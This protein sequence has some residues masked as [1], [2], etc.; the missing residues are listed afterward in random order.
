[1]LRRTQA[2]ILGLATAASAAILPMAAGQDSTAQAA[3]RKQVTTDYTLLR[4]SPAS[5]VL[6]TAYRNWTVDVH[7]DQNNGYRWG[8]V[9]GDLN[10]CLW[11]YSGALAGDAAADDSCGAAT[12][13]P[14]SMFT[15]GQ[16]GG[17]A[18]DGATVATVA[19]AGC[20]TW[21]G[22]HITGYGNVRPWDVPAGASAPVNGQVTIGQT[23]LWR[24]VSRDGNWV[25]V[26]D[27]RAGGT[28]GQGL[29]GWYFMPRGCL[30]AVLPG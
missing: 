15:N 26:R 16:I 1:M 10:T 22:S 7:G 5:Y 3:V 17:S 23:V 19:G 8:R 27:P 24:Y 28:D 4:R 14:T 30:P 20:A 13:L 9:F 12:T 11:T 18:D 29:Q 21:D 25:M 2:L 6:G